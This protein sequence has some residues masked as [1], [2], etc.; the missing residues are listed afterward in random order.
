MVSISVANTDLGLVKSY[1][2]GF[3][4]T[5]AY[6]GLESTIK[7][8]A[9]LATNQDTSSIFNFN[10]T[11]SM[12]IYNGFIGIGT[13]L[14]EQSSIAL[15][16]PIMYVDGL[17]STQLDAGGI[18]YKTESFTMISL[19][20]RASYSYKLNATTH[21]GVSGIYLYNQIDTQSAHGFSFDLGFIKEIATFKAGVSLQNIGYTLYWST[22]K[23]ETKP[24][25]VNLGLSYMPV[26]YF[27]I[28]SDISIIEESTVSNLGSHIMVSSNLELYLGCFDIGNTNQFRTG[29]SLSIDSSKLSYS[30]GRNL[31]LGDSH[32]IGFEIDF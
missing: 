1:A 19:Q 2:Q 4:T 13:T 6:M 27:E 25:K 21:V 5:A 26:N 29:L 22:D 7:N 17:D 14:T 24:V 9:G 20:P 16:S 18:G 15:S 8:P 32:K 11:Y 28:L 3:A 10:D 30:Y 31:K 12:Q 23:I